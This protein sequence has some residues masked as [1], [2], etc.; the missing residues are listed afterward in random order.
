MSKAEDTAKLVYNPK[1]G[2]W[3]IRQGITI[4]YQSVD[5]ES[6][7]RWADRVFLVLLPE[8]HIL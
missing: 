7:K 8:R 3:E 1:N 5:K 4:L 6:C 2:Y